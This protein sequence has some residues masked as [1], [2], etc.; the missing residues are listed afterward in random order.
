M[1][2]NRKKWWVFVARLW[3]YNFF[4]SIGCLV[5]I[6]GRRFQLRSVHVFLARQKPIGLLRTCLQGC[7]RRALPDSRYLFPLRFRNRDRNKRER[8]NRTPTRV[9]RKRS[10][11]FQHSGNSSLRRD[12]NILGDVVEH[13]DIVWQGICSGTKQDFVFA[14]D[15]PRTFHV[16]FTLGDDT[17][18]CQWTLRLLHYIIRSVGQVAY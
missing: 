7:P 1:N 13:E 14:L 4:S 11:V 10:E 6:G 5:F 12:E 2:Q 8:E 18:R 15:H 17:P 3:N 16:Q 9:V